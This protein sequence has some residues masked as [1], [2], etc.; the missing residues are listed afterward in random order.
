MRE[1]IWTEKIFK[2]DATYFL[3]ITNHRTTPH[4]HPV[5]PHTEG[6]GMGIFVS[7]TFLRGMVCTT[8]AGWVA[9]ICDALSGEDGGCRTNGAAGVFIR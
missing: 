6:A 8:G 1:E 7:G 3:R 2:D 5:P 9:R 4:N